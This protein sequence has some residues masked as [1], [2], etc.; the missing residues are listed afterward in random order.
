MSHEGELNKWECKRVDLLTVIDGWVGVREEGQDGTAR[1]LVDSIRLVN[2]FLCGDYIL[3]QYFLS[4]YVYFCCCFLRETLPLSLRRAFL[5]R[6]FLWAKME[7][8]QY[9]LFIYFQFIRLPGH[10]NDYAKFE[11]LSQNK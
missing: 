3:C 10:H 2:L 11:N 8:C 7:Q 9:N 1:V 5:V 4:K 6:K